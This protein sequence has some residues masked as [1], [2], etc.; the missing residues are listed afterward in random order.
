MQTAAS[1]YDRVVARCCA[2]RGLEASMPPL[3]DVGGRGLNQDA[4]AA[5]SLAWI[6]AATALTGGDA[7]CNVADRSLADC[8]MAAASLSTCGV[9]VNGRPRARIN[10]LQP[11]CLADAL[12][13]TMTGLLASRAAYCRFLH[14]P[15]PSRDG[16]HHARRIVLALVIGNLSAPSLAPHFRALPPPPPSLPPPPPSLPLLLAVV[17]RRHRR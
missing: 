15:T 1:I 5:S 8:L 6:R 4:A 14:L 11:R 2:F 10:T 3:I 13:T 16:A 9:R 17:H 12:K 7:S